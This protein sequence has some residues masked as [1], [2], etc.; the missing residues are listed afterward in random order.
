M[1]RFMTG[2]KYHRWTSEANDPDRIQVLHDN[3]PDRPAPEAL[4]RD[5]LIEELLDKRR[6]QLRKFLGQIA[7]CASKNFVY[8]YHQTCNIS[9]LD[10]SQNQRRI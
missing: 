5:D 9:R 10:I 8:Y 2:G 3:D 1:A 7:K 4:N 6:R